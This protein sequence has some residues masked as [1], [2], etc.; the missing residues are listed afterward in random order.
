MTRTFSLVAAMMLAGCGIT[1]GNITEDNYVEKSAELFCKQTERCNL[2]YF[3]SEW[4]DIDDCID[5]VI[6]DSEDAIEE[7]MDNCDFNEEAAQDCADSYAAA[8]CEEV[9]DG[10]IDDCDAEDIFEDCD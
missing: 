5:D 2:G 4:D 7:A 3:E 8:S 9:Y 6:D 1:A 10:D